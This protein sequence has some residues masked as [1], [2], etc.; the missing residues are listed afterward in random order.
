MQTPPKEVLNESMDTFFENIQQLNMSMYSQLGFG[1]RKNIMDDVMF[2][3][4]IFD[5][6][7]S[8]RYLDAYQKLQFMRDYLF[9]TIPTPLLEY[10]RI[11]GRESDKWD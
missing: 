5:L 11:K 8:K 6:I 9:K 2:L 7:I 3:C 10:I 1:Q 4:E